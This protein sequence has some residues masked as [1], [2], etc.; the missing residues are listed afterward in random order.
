M[1][2][3]KEMWAFIRRNGLR[4]ILVH[5][6]EI[7]IGALLRFLPGPEGIILRAQFYR[8]LFKSAGGKLLVYP[9]TYIVFSQRISVGKRVAFN[10]NTY[11][12]GRGGLRFGDNVMVGPNCV[13]SSCEHGYESL[14]VPMCEQPIRYSAIEVGNDVWLGGN[15]CVKSGVKIGDGSIVA[16]GPVVTKDVPPY[17]IFGGVP[18]KVIAQRADR[19]TASS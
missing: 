11:L 18:G 2:I 5:L 19:A 13:F 17:T 3:L 15:V 4:T 8:L 6:V 10:V 16:A 7:Y 9:G 14:D 12:D 1:G